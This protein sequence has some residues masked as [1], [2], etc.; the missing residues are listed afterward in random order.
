MGAASAGSSNSAMSSPPPT[1]PSSC[2]TGRV[3]RPGS[4]AAFIELTG[5]QRGR[6]CGTGRPGDLISGPET[7]RERVAEI[8]RAIAMGEPLTTELTQ[9]RARDGSPF[10]T[11]RCVDPARQRGRQDL[12]LLRGGPRHHRKPAPPRGAADRGQG[13]GRA[14]GEPRPA[15]R[16]AEP[17]LRRRCPR[18]PRRRPPP[19]PR[20]KKPPPGAHRS[21]SLQAC[22]R[23]AG[24]RRGRR[25]AV[26][27]RRHS[28]RLD[29]K[30]RR[31]R[32]DRR[33]RV[34]Q[35]SSARATTPA[36]RN[37]SRIA[38]ATRSAAKSPSQ[39]KRCRIGASF[40]IASFAR[41]PPG[42]QGPS[43]TAPT[44]PSTS[45][46]TRGA[47]LS[48]ATPKGR[49]RENPQRPH[50]CAEL[51]RALA[52]R[53]SC[54]CSSRSSMRLTHEVVGMETL[55]RW[56]HPERG[57][58]CPDRFLSVAAQMSVLPDID[59][60]IFERSVAIVAG[61]EPRRPFNIPEVLVQRHGAKLQDPTLLEDLPAGRY[62]RHQGG[63]RTPRIGADRGGE[64]TRSFLSRQT[65]A[66]RASRSR[67]TTS[68]RATRRSSGSTGCVR[69]R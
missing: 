48:C 21:R 35:S 1:T 9:P 11:D 25:G 45:P 50:A 4:T 13:G 14:P 3:W 38:C 51:E 55:M 42:V 23:H 17:A 7:S 12:R 34:R 5:L 67:S 65:C 36:R 39:G 49:A 61:A 20:A 43:R 27:C 59:A 47:V 57:R 56:D 37:S 10:R 16:A 46:R 31:S 54:R 69:T 24:T 6:D 15:H 63:D 66:R 64:A 52:R 33:R 32:A 60:Q 44:R 28:A 68:A 8:R 41:R 26:P 62:R 22:Q 40:G 19:L 29:P 58:L 18:G 53:S 2:S 30:R